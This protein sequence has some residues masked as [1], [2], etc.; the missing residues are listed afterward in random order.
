MASDLSEAQ[1]QDVVRLAGSVDLEHSPKI[2]QTLLDLGRL[3]M[4]C[5]L[6][7]LLE[8]RRGERDRLVELPEFGVG[9]GEDVEHIVPIRGSDALRGLG[10]VERR[11]AIPNGTIR[12]GGPQPSQRAERLHVARR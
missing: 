10:I 8:R 9:G 11:V 7:G 4:V 1:D 12:A 3:L 2:R 5:A 6:S